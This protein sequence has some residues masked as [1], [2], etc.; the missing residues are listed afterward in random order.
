M[1][2]KPM[3]ESVIFEILSQLDDGEQAILEVESQ[4]A[5][6]LIRFRLAGTKYAAVRDM[7]IE[8]W[9]FNPYEPVYS[10]LYDWPGEQEREEQGLKP[11]PPWRGRYRFVRMKMGEAAVAFLKEQEEGPVSLNEIVKGL[12]GGGFGGYDYTVSGR[13]IHAALINAAGVEKDDDGGYIYRSPTES[14]PF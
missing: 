14:Q 2:T 10:T 6:A 1:Q 8:R 5:L 9:G 3:N 12:E 11:R 13:A 7:A 4:L